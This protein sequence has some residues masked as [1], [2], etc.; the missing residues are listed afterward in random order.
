MLLAWLVSS[1]HWGRSFNL[2]QWS[3]G[4]ALCMIA[5]CFLVR[6]RAGWLITLSSLYLLVN[7]L[8]LFG[9]P[10][11]FR[12]VRGE[13]WAPRYGQV[14]VNALVA[15]VCFASVFAFTLAA[16]VRWLIDL[17]AAVPFYCLANAA[18]VILGSVFSF[19]KVV[20]DLS[21]PGYIDRAGDIGQPGFIDGASMNGCFVAL[22]FGALLYTKLDLRLKLF[23]ACIVLWSLYLAEAST[24]WGVLGVSLAAAFFYR[25]RTLWY[26]LLLFVPLV[27]GWALDCGGEYFSSNGRFQAYGVFFG[28]WWKMGP[29]YVVFGGGPGSFSALQEII[30]AYHGLFVSDSAMQSWLWLHSDWLQTLWEL[31]IVGL[32]AAVA[33]FAQTLYF[34]WRVRSDVGLFVFSLTSSLAA[35]AIF[36]YPLRYFAGAFLAALLP[37]LAYRV[38]N[39]REQ[40]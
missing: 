12:Y 28:E 10:G 40:S 31:G 34:S 16:P 8:T 3:I 15:F 36:Q 33:V 11:E 25:E 27:L 17:G 23:A 35:T 26:T 39:P 6:R 7:A 4:E 24:P 19:N 18:Y 13:F 22:G 38:S 29:K 1:F 37:V 32:I 5:V 20:P 2:V 21:K 14:A 30:Q 9:Q